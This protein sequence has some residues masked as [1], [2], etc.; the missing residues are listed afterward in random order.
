M[1]QS[2]RFSARWV[3][4]IFLTPQKATRV[5][6]AI[7]PIIQYEVLHIVINKFYH[8]FI[9]TQVAARPRFTSKPAFRNPTSYKSSSLEWDEN[10]SMERFCGVKIAPFQKGKV[11][12]D[13]TKRT[14]KVKK[15]HIHTH[16][17]QRN[18]DIQFFRVLPLRHNRLIIWQTGMGEGIQ[19]SLSSGNKTLLV[20]PIQLG[21]CARVVADTTD[22]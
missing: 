14:R 3:G 9:G 17:W 6:R 15:R 22:G 2:P 10:V 16:P 5:T 19:F 8:P 13:R 1:H 11:S 20:F 18:K 21:V 7:Q 12:M 4:R